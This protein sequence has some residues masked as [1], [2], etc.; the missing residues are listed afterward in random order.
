MF[1]ADSF[2]IFQEALNN[3]SNV[4]LIGHI[5]PDGDCIGSILGL[6]ELLYQHKPFNTIDAVII[7]SVPQIYNFLPH[8]QKLLNPDS[9]TLL[10]SYDIAM[11]IDCATYERMGIS[12]TIF[13][14]ANIT[15][16]IDHHI[17][18]KEYASINVLDYDACSTGQIIF[19]ILQHLKLNLTNSIATNLY[20]SIL[21]DTGGFKF[22][23]TN[24][25]CF[26]T[27]SILI[28]AGASPNLIYRECYEKKPI[29]MIKLHAECLSKISHSEDEKVYWSLVTR[30]MLSYFNAHD[31]HIEGLVELIRQIDKCEVAI[32]FKETRDGKIKISFRS[33]NINVS[34]FT[35][36]YEGGG[37]HNAAGCTLSDSTILTAVDEITS[38]V[39]QLVMKY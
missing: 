9:K 1:N 8:N 4:I 7:G 5:A 22:S 24:A 3:A 19:D 2:K 28:N 35:K 10:D 12:S 34:D 13:D 25:K 14:K 38:K 11:S 16:N 26:E 20:T 23:N 21:T 30:D 31:E 29:E 6:K 27:A 15:V 32:L 33:K 17:S 18:N 37:H 36:Q 39:I